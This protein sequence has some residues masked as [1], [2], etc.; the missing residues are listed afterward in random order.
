MAPVHGDFHDDQLLIDDD[1]RIVG[2][3]DVDG[4]GVGR[5]ADDLGTM[6]AHQT[7]MQQIAPNPSRAR[8]LDDLRSVFADAVGDQALA[9]Q[10]AAALIGLATGPYRARETGW[11]QETVRRLELALELVGEM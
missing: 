3:L 9:S 11:E 4:A 10:T 5:R 6:L 7:V 1:G 8:H 2:L